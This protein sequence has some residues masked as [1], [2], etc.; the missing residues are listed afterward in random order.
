MNRVRV[1][2]KKIPHL[3]FL[4]NDYVKMINK[5]LSIVDGLIVEFLE[6]Y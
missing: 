1:R 3:K 5:I 2:V 4:K 6:R